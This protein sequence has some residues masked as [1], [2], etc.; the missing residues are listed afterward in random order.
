MYHVYDNCQ[1]AKIASQIIYL[2]EK[3]RTHRGRDSNFLAFAFNANTE[4]DLVNVTT[5]GS[6]I[7]FTVFI[8]C[9]IMYNIESQIDKTQARIFL[10]VGVNISLH[11]INILKVS[12]CDTLH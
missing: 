3:A 5:S 9:W 10:L 1:V 2:V 11:F 12:S 8:D 7:A 4:T 6:I